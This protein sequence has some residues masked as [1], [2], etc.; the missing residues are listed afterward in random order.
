MPKLRSLPASA[1]QE[2][3]VAIVKANGAVIVNGLMTD[4]LADHVFDQTIDYI[5]NSPEGNEVF[6]GQFTTRT[7]ALV[8]RSKACCELVMNDVVLRSVNDYLSPV[9]ERV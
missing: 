7:G 8:A 9:C 5:N 6:T 2:E 4:E 3:I 1:T